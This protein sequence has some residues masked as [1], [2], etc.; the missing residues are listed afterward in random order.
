[1]KNIFGI[2]AT[3]FAILMLTDPTLAH[4]MQHERRKVNNNELVEMSGM[5]SRISSL[6]LNMLNK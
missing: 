4:R 1:M 6:S 2:G 5:G 3:S